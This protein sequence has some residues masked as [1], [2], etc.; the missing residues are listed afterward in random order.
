M[1]IVY[2][3]YYFAYIKYVY[4]NFNVCKVIPMAINYKELGTNIKIERTRKG[5]RQYE[6]ADRVN[7]SSQHMSHIECG[8][9][10]ASLALLVDIANSLETSVDA[11]LGRNQSANRRKILEAQF[12]L[13]TENAPDDVVELCV[14][15]CKFLVEWQELENIHTLQN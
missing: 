6:L 8:I 4:N 1:G 14:A 2:L 11:L 15:L 5:L 9:T 13:I 3:L 10:Q 7:V 12:G